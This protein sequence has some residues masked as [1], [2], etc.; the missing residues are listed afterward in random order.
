MPARSSPIRSCA[1]GSA[2]RAALAE[3]AA[4]PRHAAPGPV[5]PRPAA[6]AAERRPRDAARRLG[7]PPTLASGARARS[8]RDAKVDRSRLRRPSRDLA[9]ARRLDRA[10]ARRGVVAIDTETTSRSIRCGAELVGISLARRARARPATC[11]SAI[12]GGERRTVCSPAALAPDQ[13]DE[14]DA[15]ARAEAAARRSRRPEGRPRPQVRRAGARAARHRRS[16]RSTT[17]C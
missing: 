9:D 5:A 1:S 14:R 7:T 10:R 4:A 15:L 16:R 6:G 8:W 17:R 2:A 13:L 3:P 11:R 12:A